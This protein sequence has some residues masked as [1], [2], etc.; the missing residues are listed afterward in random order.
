M[1]NNNINSVTLDDADFLVWR[2]Q[3]L[4]V[5][6]RENTKPIELHGQRGMEGS[7][8]ALGNYSAASAAALPRAS[9]TLAS[10]ASPATKKKTVDKMARR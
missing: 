2:R 10:I 4:G 9:S 8:L 5:P 1:V 7:E 3:W 6:H